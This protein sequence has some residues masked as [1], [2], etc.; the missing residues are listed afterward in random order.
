MIGR[1][2]RSRTLGKDE[3][4]A[5]GY[6]WCGL[7]KNWIRVREDHILAE[8]PR[9]ASTRSLNTLHRKQKN[10]IRRYAS[11]QG[12]RLWRVFS[13]VTPERDTPLQQR[14]GLGGMI[15]H[16]KKREIQRV[17]VSGA[18][19]LAANVA[20]RVV[21]LRYFR[22]CKVRV[23]DVSH[24]RELTSDLYLDRL[25]S[26][27]SKEELAAARDALGI[28]KRKSSLSGN[29]TEVGRKP[30]GTSSKEEG[31]VLRRIFELSRMLPKD[32]RRRGN[33]RRTFDQIAE[34]LNE[35]KQPTRT[36]KPWTGSTVLGIIKRERPELYR[37][38][39]GR[40]KSK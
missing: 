7:P 34:V 2:K 1:Y 19:R 27:L 4:V 8:P 25:E 31:V 22:S 26:R 37:R 28:L 18:E 33:C 30:F 11:C 16:A 20:E 17:L 14:S 29:R 39:S 13:D 6:V 32:Q 12:H 9:P 15:F 36:G 35:E 24:P 40:Q 21:L 3:L 23:I 10:P 38:W 5:V